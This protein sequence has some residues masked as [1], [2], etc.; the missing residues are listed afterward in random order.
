MPETDADRLVVLQ[1][2]GDRTPVA[3]VHAG[4][5]FVISMAPLATTTAG[6]RPFL[7]LR[8]LHADRSRQLLRIGALARRY[9]DRLDGEGSGPLV[10]AGYSNGGV[11]AH[12]LASEL[13]ARGRRVH[14]LVLIDPTSPRLLAKAWPKRLGYPLLALLGVEGPPTRRFQQRMAVTS[15]ANRLRRARSLPVPVVVL[16]GE[17]ADPEAWAPWAGDGLEAVAVPGDHRG[18]L[19]PPLVAEVGA[20]LE[21]AIRG[22]EARAV[23]SADR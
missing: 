8:L 10:I 9:A 18:M 2:T 21:A 20:H 14:G 13:L 5:G 12:A 16:A 7:G 22:L 1:G 15:F 11:L 17:M 4:H 3:Y 23:T 6:T 19:D